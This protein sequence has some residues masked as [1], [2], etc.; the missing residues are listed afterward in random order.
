LQ[1]KELKSLLCK[2]GRKDLANHAFERQDLVDAAIDFVSK[3][4]PDLL[5]EKYDL[6]ANITLESPADVGREGKAD[7]LQQGSYKCHVQHLAT[8]Q[9]YEIQDLHVQEIMAQQIGLSESY[10]LIFRRTGI[11]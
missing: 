7:P 8:K 4:L 2:Y 5:A 6:V 11:D 3:S 10:V 9:W 1:I